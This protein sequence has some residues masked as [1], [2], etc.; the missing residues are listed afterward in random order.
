MILISKKRMN[1]L[2]VRR[3][4][5]VWMLDFCMELNIKREPV[6][7]WGIS[8]TEPLPLENINSPSMNKQPQGSIAEAAH[9]TLKSVDA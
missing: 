7:S 6:S 3:K 5:Q 1:Q 4:E 8:W 2:R 9:E